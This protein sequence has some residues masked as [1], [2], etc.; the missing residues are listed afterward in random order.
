MKIFKDP[1]T[2]LFMGFG[3]I[4]AGAW[5]LHVVAGLMMTGFLLATIGFLMHE[6]NRLKASKLET[7]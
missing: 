3:C 7:K 6:A 1:D 2:Y 4:A 5:V